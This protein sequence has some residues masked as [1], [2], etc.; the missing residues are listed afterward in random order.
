MAVYIIEHGLLF[1]YM[2]TSSLFTKHVSP[3][4]LFLKN[5]GA[6]QMQA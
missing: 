5:N 1:R 4:N 2:I 3:H 6:S